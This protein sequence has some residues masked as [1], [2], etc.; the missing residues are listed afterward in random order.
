MHFV[1]S[2]MALKGGPGR[3][4]ATVNPVQHVREFRHGTFGAPTVNARVKAAASQRDPSGADI[5]RS[6]GELSS[7][8]HE[9]LHPWFELLC[10]GDVN[11]PGIVLGGRALVPNTS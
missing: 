11:C 1:P 7:S 2:S 4:C 5:R 9:S 8:L 3:V 10:P 6:R